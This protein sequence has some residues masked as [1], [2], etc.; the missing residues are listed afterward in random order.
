VSSSQKSRVALI[1]GANLW[2]LQR[3]VDS[4]F[5][6]RIM[7]GSDFAN[8][9][10]SGIEV[11]VGAPFLSAEEKAD[12]ALRQRGSI[13]TPLGIRLRAMSRRRAA[14][15][16]I[17]VGVS[18]IVTLTTPQALVTQRAIAESGASIL[19]VCE[20]CATELR[21]AVDGIGDPSL[22]FQRSSPR[23]FFTR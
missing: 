6:G 23:A 3:L 15:H 9:V 18:A 4:G 8:Q 7:F 20:E 17:S 21:A 10:E 16:L 2:H 14:D 22:V 1:T 12:L 11:I 5:A 19:H 13:P